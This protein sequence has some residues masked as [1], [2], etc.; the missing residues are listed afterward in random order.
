M[1]PWGQVKFFAWGFTKVFEVFKV[2]HL[3]YL[4]ILQVYLEVYLGIKN[5]GMSGK[6]PQTLGQKPTSSNTSQISI[7]TRAKNFL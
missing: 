3:V 1:M 4:G 6:W 7:K 2:K 5:L